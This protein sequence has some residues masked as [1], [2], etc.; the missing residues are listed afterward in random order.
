MKAGFGEES[1]TPPLG[2]DLSGYGFYLDRK[3]EAILDPLKVRVLCLRR[4]AQ[5]VVLVSFDLLGFT[6]SFC[7]NLRTRLGSLLPAAP[8][9]VLIS[10]T[11]THTAPAVQ[12]LPGMGQVNSEYVR[13]LQKAAERATRHAIENLCDTA[14]S[15]AFET[16]EPIG[17]NR[18]LNGFVNIDPRLKVAVFQQQRRKIL[19]VGYAC[20]PVTLGRVSSVSA[21]WPGAMIQKLEQ[22]GY[23]TVFLQGFCGDIDPVTNMNRW[24][25]GTA[26]DVR[27][28][29]G[30][31][32]Q[33]II[34]AI[35]YAVP[36][37]INS[38]NTLETRVSLPVRILNEWEIE[39][40]AELFLEHYKDYRSAAAF[41]E[42]WKRRAVEMRDM[43]IERAR[44]EN[45]PI[46]VIG[47]GGFRILGLPG[48]IFCKMGLEFQDEWFP[49]LPA[50]FANGNI[51]YLPEKRTF[52]DPVNYVQLVAPKIYS[53]FPFSPESIDIVMMASRDLLARIG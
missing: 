52:T 3:A 39:R 1:I 17:Y 29:G 12:P 13:F 35:Q 34:K 25:E 42:T 14:F 45:V 18:D 33:R 37:D 26:E 9:N 31:L 16:I 2:L 44:I 10:C 11:H 19:L 4:E 41:I 27:Y 23:H 6:V 15:Y 50:G 32:A 40:D 7:D 46:H 47:I 24:G 8:E 30:M 22:E 43:F 5:V 49:L 48:E 51:G 38:I 20:H 21:D 36:E 53:V 28:Y